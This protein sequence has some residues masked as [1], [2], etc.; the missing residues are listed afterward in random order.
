MK[1]FNGSSFYASSYEKSGL[2][3]KSRV[4]LLQDLLQPR[5]FIAAEAA[6]TISFLP[7]LEY[8]VI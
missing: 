1:D 2:K 6:P 5:R 4:E 8:S 3:S 7:F